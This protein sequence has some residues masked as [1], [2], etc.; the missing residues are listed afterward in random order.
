MF[1]GG[2]L[3]DREGERFVRLDEFV[4]AR[5]RVFVFGDALPDG[6]AI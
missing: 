2:L 6:R 3:I 1:D 4:R 5:Y